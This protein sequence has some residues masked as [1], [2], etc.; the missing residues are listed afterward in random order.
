MATSVA[1]VV[2]HAIQSLDGLTVARSTADN[3]AALSD[4]HLPVEHACIGWPGLEHNIVGDIQRVVDQTK[5]RDDT[6]LP[7][8]YP[9]PET[10]RS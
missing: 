4:R 6:D 1:Q 8:F 7:H 5:R 10:A 9:T 2:I 3:N